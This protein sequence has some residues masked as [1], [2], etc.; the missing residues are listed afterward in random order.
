ML[1]IGSYPEDPAKY[2]VVVNQVFRD[3]ADPDP[4]GR[5]K[6]ICYESRPMDGV[7]RRGINLGVSPD[8]LA[9]SLGQDRHIIDYN[10]DSN[11]HLVM[12]TE[13]GAWMLY[14]R[15]RCVHATGLQPQDPMPGYQGGRHSS[16]RIAVMTST[17]LEHWSYPRTCLYPDESDTPDYD[18]ACVFHNGSHYI[19]LY[20]AFEGDDEG[21]KEI[22]LASS[23]D[24][25]VW[26][27]TNPRAAFIPR[28]RPGDWDAGELRPASPPIQ[29]LSSTYTY[30]WGA[31][32]G[33]Y[34]WVG[35][36]GVGL[37]I[38]KTDRYV[39]Q[40]ADDEQG[41]LIT[42]EFILEGNR[43]YVNSTHGRTGDRVR[44]LRVE[45]AHHPELGKHGG[46]NSAFEGF[47]FDDCD[48]HTAR[49]K[50]IGGVSSINTIQR[51]AVNL[52]VTWRGSP[53][54]S[55]LKGKAVYLRFRLQNMGIFSFRVD[56]E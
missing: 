56:N 6:M 13:E 25:F 50:L 49:S 34:D 28:G 32:R 40:R 43:L 19:M 52:P 41:Y 48:P 36:A 22:K 51:N 14:C 26:E 3:D 53:D 38:G 11:N 54:L 23:A 9:W 27:R 39:E 33:Q 45:V 29:R 44:E 16:R 17:D 4:A 37:V 42:K 30:Y 8:G 46:F 2:G 18:C 31:P 35:I 55:S 15:A 20:S 47:S 21:C 1:Y 5:Y 10:S 12:N 7:Y 24:G